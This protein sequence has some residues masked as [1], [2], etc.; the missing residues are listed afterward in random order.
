[1]KLILQIISL[2]GLLMTIVPPVLF[3]LEKISLQSQ[4]FLMSAG[5][6]IWFISASFWL[7]SKGNS[8]KN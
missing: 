2:A 8:V 3:F 7:G 4:N 5:T 6:I 1:M